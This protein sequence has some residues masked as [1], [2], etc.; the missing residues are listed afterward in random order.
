MSDNAFETKFHSSSGTRSAALLVGS[1]AAALC[2]IGSVWILIAVP[3][4]VLAAGWF[5]APPALLSLI[6]WFFWLQG[7]ERSVH[8][9]P[10]HL[11][12]RRRHALNPTSIAVPRTS[13]SGFSRSLLLVAVYTAVLAWGGLVLM[14]LNGAALGLSPYVLVIPLIATVLAIFASAYRGRR[15]A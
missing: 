7:R 11:L 1:Y 12:L 13:R 15:Q 6:L 9:E 10:Q 2:W 5:L 3:A 8:R 14:V 4:L